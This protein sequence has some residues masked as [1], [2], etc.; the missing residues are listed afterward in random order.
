M[1]T[2]DKLVFRGADTLSPYRHVNHQI[3]I[4]CVPLILTAVSGMLGGKFY[5]GFDVSPIIEIQ[6]SISSV[7]YQ[8][9]SSFWCLL[10][11]Y[12]IVSLLKFSQT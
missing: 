9:G 2:R 3:D 8:F 4:S 1:S 6:T 7:S 5:A 10:L 11:I 12:L